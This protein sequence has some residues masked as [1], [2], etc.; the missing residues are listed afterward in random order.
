M[1]GAC[2]LP[3]CIIV[4]TQQNKESTINYSCPIPQLFFSLV[5]YL[6]LFAVCD[7]HNHQIMSAIRALRLVSGKFIYQKRVQNEI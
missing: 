2:L 6:V 3:T 1:T 5:S 7:I 4:Q